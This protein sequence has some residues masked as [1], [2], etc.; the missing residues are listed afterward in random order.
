MPQAAADLVLHGDLT[1]KYAVGSYSK[2][3]A[4]RRSVVLRPD[5]Q[6]EADHGHR[7]T[8]AIACHVARIGGTFDQLMHLL[9][10]PDHQGGHHAR[11]IELRSGHARARDY[12]HRVWDNA[13]SAINSTVAVESRQQA[14]EDLAFLRDRIETTPWRGERGR[15]ALRVLRAHL[16]FAEAAGGRQHAASERQAAEEA[17]ISRQTLRRAYEGV[18]KPGGWL[19]RIRVGHGTE[20]STWYLGTG[21]KDLPVRSQSHHRTTQFPPDRDLEE[22]STPETTVTAD[23][24]STVISR[25]MGHN[26]FAHRG[27]GSPSLMVIGALHLRPGQTAKELITTA[28]VSRATA[29]RTLQR[30]STH[31]VVHRTGATWT[32]ATHALDGIDQSR[33]AAPASDVQVAWAW[34]GIAQHYATAGIAAQRKALHAAERVAYRQALEQ[35]SEHRSKV[36]VIVR[37]GRQILVPTPRGDEIPPDWQ[38]PGG[39]VL[40]PTTGRVAPEWRVATDGHLI[41]ISPADQRSYDEL[42]AAHAEAVNEWESAA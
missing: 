30:L 38:L 39:A 16:N 19:R 34:D 25:L 20:G 37:D 8:A 1:G 22:W 5:R 32:L 4:D 11:T 24:D 7:I 28:S 3:S 14:Q 17:G 12:V 40:N 23:I 29:Y 15:T 41:L 33:T 31:G 26:A 9:M 2:L 35:L 10:P 18:L 27:L 21:P 42:V 36:L 13:C 6:S